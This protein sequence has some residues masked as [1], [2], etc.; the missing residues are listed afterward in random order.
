MSLQDDYFDL[1]DRL[2]DDPHFSQALYRIWEAF[3]EM[4]VEQER[5]SKISQGFKMMVEGCFPPEN[6][7]EAE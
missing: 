5:L 2:Q 3:C 7:N 4:E 1:E 6:K